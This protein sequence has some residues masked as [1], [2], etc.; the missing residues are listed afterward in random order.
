MPISRVRSF[1]DT[2]RMFMMPMPATMAVITPTRMPTRLV[3]IMVWL[4]PW[5]I[6][7]CRL[8]EKLSAWSGPR[9]RAA[10]IT[11]TI[12]SSVSITLPAGATTAMVSPRRAP[13]VRRKELSG[14]TRSPSWE[15]PKAL[16]LRTSEPTTV[17]RAVGPTLRRWPSG[18]WPLKKAS[19]RS[20][21]MTQASE[22]SSWSRSL[23]KRPRRSC[24]P[25][26]SRKASAVP[27]TS[28][29]ATSFSPRAT[30]ASALASG[31]TASGSVA[32]A[33][34]AR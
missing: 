24:Q 31:A 13:K 25:P 3:T 7:S 30:T 12:S 29:W 6:L 1:T 2:R 28:T 10:R 17:Q 5:R 23:M 16:P 33:T 8:T 26:A 34:T 15:R 32:L 20:A 11:A 9:R 21:P 27:R 18:S 22:P 19:S 14:S 4:K